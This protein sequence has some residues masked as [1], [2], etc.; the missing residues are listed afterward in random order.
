MFVACVIVVPATVQL[1][2]P[3]AETVQAS[4]PIF[5]VKVIAFAPL[6]TSNCIS[7]REREQAA[8]FHVPVLAIILVVALA[9]FQIVLAPSVV[10]P[11]FVSVLLADCVTVTDAE[12]VRVSFAVVVHA[13][14]EQ[15][16]VR[17]TVHPPPPVAPVIAE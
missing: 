1:R 9:P 3:L 11:A 6:V 13:P 12:V 17:F 16:P 14:I 15:L 5:P 7:S 8:Q 2:L 10:T 4:I